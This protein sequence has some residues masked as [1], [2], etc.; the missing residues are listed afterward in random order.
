MEQAY[1]LTMK[2]MMH[3][4][5]INITNKVITINSPS[6]DSQ[7]FAVYYRIYPILVGQTISL[8]P[9]KSLPVKLELPAEK[10]RI[11]FT[12]KVWFWH[13][14]IQYD[15]W[16]Q[17]I[18]I[19]PPQ[20]TALSQI[21]T[22]PTTTNSIKITTVNPF[23]RNKQEIFQ[24]STTTKLTSSTTS[25]ATSKM[26]TT[27]SK[28]SKIT[29][30]TMQQEQHQD[31]TVIKFTGGQILLYLGQHHLLIQTK[32]LKREYV[33]VKLWQQ[34]KLVGRTKI[35]AQGISKIIRFPVTNHLTLLLS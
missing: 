19:R 34:E 10:Y 17:Y 12:R 33:K 29:T 27:T 9:P 8:H 11:E 30:I 3:Y 21:K 24:S 31:V 35:T 22:P 7:T 14:W 23:I 5:P 15:Q 1:E 13:T 28:V 32:L 6:K 16:M 25:Q 2:L 4:L 18:E 26:I 20:P